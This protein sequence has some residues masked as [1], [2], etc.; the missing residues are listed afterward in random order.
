MIVEELQG[1]G[2]YGLDFGARRQK[3]LNGLEHIGLGDSHPAVDH[4]I[5]VVGKR[6]ADGVQRFVPITH[7]DGAFVT[8]RHMQLLGQ[9]SGYHHLVRY[10]GQMQGYGNLHLKRLVQRL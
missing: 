2:M 6:K 5:V 3:S 8:N 10:I 1:V 9:G 4:A 7:E